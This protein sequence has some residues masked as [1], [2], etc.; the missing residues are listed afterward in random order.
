MFNL[1]S[2]FKFSELVQR[3]FKLDDIQNT[4]HSRQRTEWTLL[5]MSLCTG[6][7][8]VENGAVLAYPVHDAN[9]WSSCDDFNMLYLIHYY[10]LHSRQ[11]LHRLCSL[12][13]EVTIELRRRHVLSAFADTRR[14]VMRPITAATAIY[15]SLFTQSVATKQEKS[16]QKRRHYRLH[17]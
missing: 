2:I 5:T 6:L 16:K 8:T 7:Q 17:S 10:L 1:I 12:C 4:S 14:P 15:T 9:S 11:L 13:F 3:T